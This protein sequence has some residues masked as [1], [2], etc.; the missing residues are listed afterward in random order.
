ME[1]T[2]QNFS[3]GNTLDASQLNYMEN[4]IVGIRNMFAIGNHCLNKPYSFQN[5][6]AYFFG[7]SVTFGYTSKNQGKADN[8]GFPKVFS[9]K[10]GLT[11]TNYGISGATLSGAV[12]GYGSI[13]SSIES[14]PTD[15]DFYFIAGGIN[16][17]QL[18]VD[19]TTFRTK[20][21]EICEYLKANIS[22]EVIFITPI[23]IFGRQA[24]R[25]QTI[26][27][28]AYRDIITELALVNGFSVLQGTLFD[29]PTDDCAASF[30]AAVIDDKI[31]PTEIGYE[32]FA[33]CMQTA[34]L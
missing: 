10:V 12:S 9:D 13:K 17:W 25:P 22:G 29:I 34:L 16:D 31:H 32:I 2:K 1:Y 28:Q 15:A 18:A 26:D 8:G 6:K 3:N 24:M 30:G 4:G 21:T 20:V 19:L 7:D 11:F 27:P 14:A 33:K 5:K 23:N